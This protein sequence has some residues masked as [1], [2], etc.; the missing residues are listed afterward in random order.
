MN[1]E[2]GEDSDDDSDD[3]GDFKSVIRKMETREFNSNDYT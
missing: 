2:I 3:E 1:E